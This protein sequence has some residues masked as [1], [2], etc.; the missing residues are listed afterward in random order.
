MKNG[1]GGWLSAALGLAL[2]CVSTVSTGSEMDDINARI[3]A[4]NA[5]TKGQ[6]PQKVKIDASKSG[7][8]GMTTEEANAYYGRMRRG[9][10]AAPAQGQRSGPSNANGVNPSQSSDCNAAL[11]DYDIE[12]HSIRYDRDVRW[13]ADDK[14]LAAKRAAVSV[15][16]QIDLPT[17]A[18]AT[19][20]RNQMPAP[21]KIVVDST[22]RTYTTIGGGLAV[23]TSGGGQACPI[24]GSVVVCP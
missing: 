6:P 9:D 14:R 12:S 18:G 7:S 22:G 17:E 5:E 11:R 24:A 1:L 23:P 3:R 13:R 19:S 8:S 16:C 15:H 4:R 10:E 21:G 2:L 20:T